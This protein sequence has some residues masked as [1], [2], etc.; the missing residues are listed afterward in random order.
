MQSQKQDCK[1]PSYKSGDALPYLGRDYILEIRQYPSY[2]K[3]G[4]QL[5]GERLV[6][7]A[8]K[9]DP[10][11]VRRAVLEWY[12]MRACSIIPERVAYYQ[13][14]VAKPVNV[15]RIKDVRSRWGSCS[16]KGNLNFNWRLVLAPMEVLD[17][18]VVHELCHLRE[19]N[20]SKAFWSLVEGILP[21]Y[22]KRREW[23]KKCKLIEA[24]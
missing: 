22:R 17:Y 19:M 23:L 5:A 6:V 9:P 24:F 16:S 20:H 14:Q 13:P 2:R 4:V 11:T 1:K 3:P 15:I 7:L 21:D 18:V 8:A 10:D 12:G